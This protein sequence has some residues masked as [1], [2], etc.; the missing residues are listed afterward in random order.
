M[1][2]KTTKPVGEVTVDDL[3]DINAAIAKGKWVEIGQDKQG[4]VKIRSVKRELIKTGRGK[5]RPES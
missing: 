2:E 1:S 3:P 5:V 4:T